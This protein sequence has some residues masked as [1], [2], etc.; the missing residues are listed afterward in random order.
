[1]GS[2]VTIL[3]RNL[4]GA[5]SVTFGGTAAVSFTVQ[6]DGAIVAT[7]PAGALTGHVVVTTPAGAAASISVFTVIP[8][9]SPVPAITGFA[10]ASGVRGVRVTISGSGFTGATSVTFGGVRAVFTVVNDSRI[11]AIVPFGARTGAIVV[12]TAGG[13]ATS[14]TSFTI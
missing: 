5:T 9:V 8:A 10:P 2:S 4:G 11:T 12:T 6:S 3:G 13:A 7:V 14:A 1:M